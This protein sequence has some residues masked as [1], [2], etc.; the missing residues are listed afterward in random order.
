MK[1]LIGQS[2]HLQTIRK[3]V[4]QLSRSMQPLIIIGEIGVGKSV[5]AENIHQASDSGQAPYVHLNLAVTDDLRLRTLV[6]SVIDNR[7]YI[8]PSTPGHGTFELSR[9]STIAIEA[10]E[11]S[12][13]AARRT[14]AELV[15]NLTKKEPEIRLVLLLTQPIESFYRNGDTLTGFWKSLEGWESLVVLPLRERQEDI[16]ELIEHFVRQTAREL[17]LGEMIVDINAVSILVRREWKGNI[18]ELKTFIEQAMM[19][20]GNKDTF[21][22]PESLMDEQSELTRILQR[23]DKGIDFALDRSIELI[24]RRILERVLSKFEF[25]QSRAARF[26]K[27][28][29]DTLRYR[30]K[31]LGIPTASSHESFDR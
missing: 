29:E 2:N 8:N 22:L 19:L 16:P 9:G 28:T 11:T 13:L 25:N 15:D 4:K 24:E 23:I 31:K 7:V 14:I 1:E 21:T 5:I 26:L 6:R 18:Q 27:I 10:L 20:S 17:N 12:G 30:M 3:K